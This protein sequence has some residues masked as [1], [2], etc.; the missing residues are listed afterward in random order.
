M[1]TQSITPIAI[2]TYCLTLMVTCILAYGGL[3]DQPWSYDDLEHIESA[4]RSLQDW[5][6]IA[7]PTAKEPTRWVL[8]LYFRCAYWAFGDEPG[9]YHT[10]N[11]VLHLVNSLLCANLLLQLFHRPLLAGLAG[12]LFALNCAPYEA[13]YEI[14]AAGLLIG[15]AF[16]IQS[17][18]LAHRGMETGSRRTILSGA[19][20]FGLALFSYESLVSVILP[21]AYLWWSRKRRES[22]FLPI[23]YLTMV[24]GFLLIDSLYYGTV[25][26]KIGFNAIEL[27]VHAGY[28]LLFFVGR[29]FLN[30]YFTP[31]GWDSPAPFDVP[32]E[33]FDTYA[34]IGFLLIGFLIYR[35]LY[36]RIFKFSTIWI[37]PALLPYLFGTMDFYFPRYWYLASVGSSLLYSNALLWLY[38]IVGRKA[39]AQILVAASLLILGW[40]S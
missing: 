26:G 16:S 14:S 4:R 22:L 12:F 27:G 5:S 32:V 34:F 15:T 33:A 6:E 36:S 11:I 31:F 25:T 8:N 20:C 18:S 30:A 17:V 3:V 28:N 10:A 2:L 35:S 23:S 21:I 9:R 38:Q 40:W 13:I 19:G 7:A 39:I 37:I 29:L 24:A 1:P